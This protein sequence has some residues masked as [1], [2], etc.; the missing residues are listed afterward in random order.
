MKKNFMA[1]AI[2]QAKIA[3]EKDEVPVGAIIVENNKIIARSHNNNLHLK[4]PTAHAE[5]LALRQASLIK[6]SSR[7]DNCDI[8]ITLEPCVMCAAAISLARIRRI[9]YAASDEKFGAIENG[10]KIFHSSSCYHK[11]EIYSGIC[12]EEAKE[13]LRKFFKSKR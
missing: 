11:A 10:I 8:Y 6:N 5:I 12:E 1:E 9:Y 3:F 7:L 2:A 4:D 13:I